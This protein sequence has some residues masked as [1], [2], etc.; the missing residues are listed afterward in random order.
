VAVEETDATPGKSKVRPRPEP[1]CRRGGSLGTGCRSRRRPY[2]IPNPQLAGVDAGRATRS[3][4]TTPTN[5]RTSQGSR[6]S[7][8]NAKPRWG[9]GPGLGHLTS[10]RFCCA[11]NVVTASEARE[12]DAYRDCSNR[13]LDGNDD[14][15]RHKSSGTLS[16]TLA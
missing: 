8:S 3:R 12:A 9:C 10:L 6:G 11:A 13:L 1:S 5:P 7:E 15:R 2:A 4:M 14:R 16:S